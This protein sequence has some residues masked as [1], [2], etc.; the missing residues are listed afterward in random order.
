MPSTKS[1]QTSANVPNREELLQ[2]AIDAARRGQKDGARVMF[3]QILEQDKRNERAMMWMAKLADS[4]S[5]RIKWL[6]ATLTVNPDNTQ[7]RQALER[8][9]YAGAAT[10]NRTLVVFGVVAA[11]LIFVFIVIIVMLA[12]GIIG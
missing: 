7:A 8:I 1:A 9:R 2:L 4:K 6:E 11:V 10:E 5:E 3:R 12:L